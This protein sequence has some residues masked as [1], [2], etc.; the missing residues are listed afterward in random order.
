MERKTLAEVIEH[1][2]VRTGATDS[3]VHRIE[4]ELIA[5]GIPL[6]GDAAPYEDSLRDA[7]LS[8]LC[9]REDPS[10][11]K[12]NLRDLQAAY[13]NLKR[14]YEDVVERMETIAATLRN[15]VRFEKEQVN[16]AM[17]PGPKEL[18]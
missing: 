8:D 13:F 5:R 16:Y 11:V 3:F 2:Q 14:H 9:Q 1:L 12:D 18:N 15:H 17:V 7:F 10:Y 6:D 4:S